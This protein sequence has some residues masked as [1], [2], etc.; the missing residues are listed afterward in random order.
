MENAQISRLLYEI[1]DLLELQKADAFRI[2][3]YRNAARV[4][5]DVGQSL[6]EMHRQGQN[7]A[8][9]P[10]IGKSTAEK[11]V[12]IIQTG[13][14]D[15][16]EELRKLV[17]RDLPKLMQVPGLGPRRAWQL[18]EQLGLKSLEELREACEKHKVASLEGMGEKT[19]KKILDGL[20]MLQKSRGR[21]LYSEA[22]RQMAKLG[23]YLSSLKSIKRW[24]AAGSL[25][26]KVETIGD[27]D[28]L[29][30]AADRAAATAAI[31]KYPDVDEITSSGEERVSLRLLSGLQVDFR[32]FQTGNFGAALMYFTGSK[33]HNIALRRIAQDHHWKLNEYGLFEGKRIIA[34]KNEDSVYGRLG[35]SWVEPELRED[36]GEVAAALEG[37]LPHLVKTADIHGD[38]HCHTTATDG[39]DD[40]EAMAAAAQQRGYKFLAI[41]D[42]SQAV[43]IANGL[44]EK[45]L[46]RHAEQIR[47][48]GAK[49]KGFWLLAGVEVDILKDGCLDIDEKLLADLDWVVASVHSALE[50]DEEQMTER[51]LRAAGSGFINALGHPLARLIGKRD[52]IRFN[53]EKVFQACREH[54]VYLEINSQPDRLDLSD[55]LCMQARQI[56]CKFVISTDSHKAVDLELIEFGVNVARRAWLTPADVLNTASIA[57]L[58]KKARKKKL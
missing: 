1:A 36:R 23:E 54:G 43:R 2:R 22:A 45:R 25:R 41:T 48:I 28:I 58:R 15:R 49:L 52:P 4:L 35:L 5:S 31:A 55:T 34:G 46:R 9:L 57:Q 29:I 32:F 42:H 44:D 26:R 20:A 10:G 56:G 13:T 47:R 53:A 12:Q 14:C 16:L 38:F 19:E 50:M 21:I 24:E 39:V 33:A 37:K 6:E 8:D 40:I 18:H 51:I 11:I 7:L 30:L 27:L 17:P 3:A